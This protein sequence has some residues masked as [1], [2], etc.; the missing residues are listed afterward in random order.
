MKKLYDIRLLGELIKSVRVASKISA[1]QFMSDVGIDISTFSRI[2]A[3]PTESF[4]PMASKLFPVIEHAANLPI[5]KSHEFDFTPYLNRNYGR[6]TVCF[7]LSF[8]NMDNQYTI[9]TKAEESNAG[10]GSLSFIDENYM[11]LA[12]PIKDMLENHIL[13]DKYCKAAFEIIDKKSSEYAE[14]YK[15]VFDDGSTDEQGIKNDFPNSR[16]FTSDFPQRLIYVEDGL[17]M[18][19]PDNTLDNTFQDYISE[20]SPENMLRFMLETLKYYFRIE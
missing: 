5:I 18:M 15:T 16:H 8:C 7:F 2:E 17:E 9:Y 6:Q 20:P 1:K 19:P 11:S 12:K 13:V 4:S 3:P 10:G 14:K